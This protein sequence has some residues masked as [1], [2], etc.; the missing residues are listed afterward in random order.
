[1]PLLLGF[2]LK[3]GSC[4]RCVAWWLGSALSFG[5]HITYWAKWY[6]AIYFALL[7]ASLAAAVAVGLYILGNKREFYSDGPDI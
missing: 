7:G 2:P 1:M 4:S 5:I 3:W 6:G